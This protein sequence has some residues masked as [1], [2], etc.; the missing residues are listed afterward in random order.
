MDFKKDKT[1]SKKQSDA[2]GI[3]SM[4]FMQTAESNKKE[5]LKSDAKALVDQIENES[6][7][8]GLFNTSNKFS[9]IANKFG[10]ASKVAAF[11]TD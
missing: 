5:R 6:E 10:G 1:K 4:K 11:D 9:K 8:E 3:M 7:E 2:T